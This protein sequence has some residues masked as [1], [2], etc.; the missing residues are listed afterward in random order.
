LEDSAENHIGQAFDIDTF[1][2]VAQSIT[3]QTVSLPF[4]VH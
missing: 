4:G 1:D 3:A 2:K